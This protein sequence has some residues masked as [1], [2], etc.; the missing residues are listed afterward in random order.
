MNFI[1]CKW[2]LNLK[3]GNKYELWRK[4]PKRNCLYP[5]DKDKCMKLLT[6]LKE[7]H[8]VTVF[9]QLW[10]EGNGNP[11]QFSC[12]ENPM[13]RGAWWAAVPGVA[14]TRTWL[15]WLSMF[16]CVGEG[17]GNPLPCSSLE[18]PRDRG[19]W[20]AAVCGVAQSQTQLKWL[21]S[22]SSSREL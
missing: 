8:S 19:A 15:K 7:Q 17:N 2:Y 12:L 14:Q 20:W 16:A 6:I 13:D 18:N 1:L 5:K 3:N 10:G 21:S 11:L 9:R 22:S 4:F